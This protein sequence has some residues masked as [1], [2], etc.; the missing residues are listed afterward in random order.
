[1]KCLYR[2]DRENMPGSTREVKHAEEEGVEF[3]WLSAPEGFDGAPQGAAGKRAAGGVSTVIGHRMRLGGRDATGRGAPVK[4]EGSAFRLPA[5]LV[6]KALGFDG[7]PLP[8]LFKAPELALTVWGTVRTDH[9]TL[10]TSLDGVFAAGDIV[11]GAS[12]VVWA[13]RDGRE[14]AAGIDRYI[15]AKAA[16][17]AANAAITAIAAE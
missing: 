12:L 14:A 16:G 4:V 7:E 2:R 6:I 3:V 10:M 9:R 5:D 11:R 13:I 17:A 1:V 15:Q 8:V